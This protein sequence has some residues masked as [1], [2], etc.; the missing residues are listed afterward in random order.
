[1]FLQNVGNHLHIPEEY[2]LRSYM[3]QFIFVNNVLLLQTY[4]VND[5]NEGRGME[6]KKLGMK[7]L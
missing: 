6:G 2:D 5:K 7:V 1:M 3:G 4:V